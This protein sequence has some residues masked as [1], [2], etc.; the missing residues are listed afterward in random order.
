MF[1]IDAA[2]RPA[3]ITSCGRPIMAKR[4]RF[5]TVLRRVHLLLALF[6]APWVLMYAIS[7]L[8]MHHQKMFTGEDH[9]VD[10]GY[11]TV[12]DG[13]YTRTFEADLDQDV[14]ATAILADLDLDGAHQVRGNLA[15][16]G[17]LTIL[18]DRPIGSLRITFDQNAQTVRVE[19]Q[20]YA[21]VYTLEMLHRRRGYAQPYWLNDAWA[22]IVD[23]FIVAVV[24]WAL[25]GLWMWWEMVKTR[26]LGACCLG[27]GVAMFAVFL[28][29]L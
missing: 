16:R 22:V 9:R 17:T 11:T 4:I 21:T 28:L 26:Q 15:R 3:P 27:L 12:S 13:P 23:A 14:I 24:L 6:L 5:S 1:Y 8:A 2:G 10:P 19:K 29:V 18:R 20:N 7:T 25:T